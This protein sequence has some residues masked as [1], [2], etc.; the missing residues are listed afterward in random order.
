MM[1]FSSRTQRSLGW[2]AAFAG[3]VAGELSAQCLH[4][5]FRDDGRYFAM[6]GDRLVSGESIRFVGVYENVGVNWFQEGRFDARNAPGCNTFGS[7]G[8][9]ALDGDTIVIGDRQENVVIYELVGGTWTRTFGTCAVGSSALGGQAVAADAG[10]V[11][12]KFWD[13]AASAVHIL[14]KVAGVWTEVALIEEPAGSGG[15]SFGQDLSLAG[16]TLFVADEFADAVFVYA[17]DGAVW[18]VTPTQVLSPSVP[19]PGFATSMAA[20]GDDLAVG[21]PYTAPGGAVVMFEN[22]GGLWIE[23]QTLQPS[24]AAVGILFGFD[25]DLAGDHLVAAAPYMDAPGG[26][27]MTGGAYAFERTLGLWS[28]VA[29]LVPPGVSAGSTL[30]MRVATNG[31][32]DAM[33]SEFFPV[34]T[35]VMAASG[36]PCKS[37]SSPQRLLN[38]AGTVDLELD[39]GSAQA[40]RMYLIA[41]S[42]S[43]NS[44][45]FF[46][47]G[48]RIPLNADEYL[49][50][51]VRN[52]NSGP[53]NETLGTLDAAG[54]ATASITVPSTPS[55]FGLTLHHAY[56]VL[57]RGLGGALTHVSNSVFVD[58]R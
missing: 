12:Y 27:S 45:G 38:G 26:E 16:D 1:N 44:P 31:V 28:E 6:E 41:G 18:S 17:F 34:D 4:S 40:N 51:I 24:S 5:E 20:S 21:A 53:F 22:V 32:L 29:P 14:E 36:A 50:F 46:L 49:S 11:A 8:P 33:T 2:I 19:S 57:A 48:E 55:L 42:L 39:A 25:V 3:L 56:I 7:P 58:L 13:G 9:L 23:T 30:G 15:F 10:R 43:G 37:L 52:A 35:F 54:Q 47:R